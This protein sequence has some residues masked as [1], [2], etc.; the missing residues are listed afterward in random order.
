MIG[1][2]RATQEIVTGSFSFGITKIEWI[3]SFPEI[4][5]KFMFI[6]VTEIKFQPVQKLDIYAVMY[7]KN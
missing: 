3:N 4:M 1:K 5:A 6:Q 2:Q 7:I